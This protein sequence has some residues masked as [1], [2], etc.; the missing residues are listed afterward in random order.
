M[1]GKKRNALKHGANTTEVML[2]NERYE[3]HEALGDALYQEFTPCGSTEEY[4]V[5]TLFDCV[6]ADGASSVISG[7]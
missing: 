4:L 2:W 5:R 1:A 6:G 7:S 3:D